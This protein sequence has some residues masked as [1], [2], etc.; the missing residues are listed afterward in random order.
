MSDINHN[1]LAGLNEKQKASILTEARRVLVLAGAGS[2]KTKTVISK[3]LYLIF[4]K[5]IK[6]SSI[7]AITFTKNAANEMIDRLIV[8]SDSSNTYE[9]F[10][11]NK[12]I[13][14]IQKDAERKKR[15]LAQ[16]WISNLTI[17]TFHSL[18]YK[19]LR[20]NGN[21]VFD[22][23]FKLITE[24]G[25]DEAD[26]KGMDIVTNERPKDIIGKML[27][28]ACEDRH[29]FLKLKR[30]ILDYY[31][32]KI[33]LEKEIKSYINEGQRTYTTLKGE[34]VKSKS[35]R[36]IADWLFRHNIKYIYE[37]VTNFKD[38]NFKPDFFIPQANLY[39][40]HVTDKSYSMENKE[41]QF[42][43]SGK[44]CVITYESI[45]NN[46]M[47]FN[48]SME[49]IIMGKITA[50]ISESISLNFEEEFKSYHDKVGEFLKTVLRLQSMMKAEDLNPTDLLKK[51]SSNEHERIRVFYEL[52]IPLIDSYKKYCTNK[53]YLDFDD[54]IVL[55]V[56]LL[57]ENPEVRAFYQNKYKYL[58]VD[59]FQD[60]NGLQVKLLDLL[61]KPENQLFC[62]GDDWQ[63]IYGFRGSDVEYIVNYE[64]YYKDCE[65]YKLEVNYRSTQTIVGA[66]NEVIKNNKRQISK[67]IKAFKKAPNKIQIFRAKSLEEDGVEFLV[68]EVKK[69]YQKG[70][71]KD[72]IL[73][74]YRRSK[75]FNEYL[76]AL[77]ENRLFVSS[78]TIHAAKGLEAKAVF[79]IG[80]K[81]GS[82]GFPD[83]WLD[84]AI[85]RIIK[86]I[87][88]DILLEEERRLFY[89][90]ITR[91][92]DEL[93]LITE[94]GNESSFVEEIPKHFFH[95]DKPKLN[96]IE[97]SIINCDKC[98]I[99]INESDNFCSHCGHKLT[100]KESSKTEPKKIPDYVEKARLVHKNAYMNW[101][102]ENDL[103][104]KELF[105]AGKSKEELSN[106]FGRNIGA[107]NARINKLG[108]D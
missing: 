88:Y 103:K 22:N 32:D 107:I 93:F 18:C 57:K 81:E 75:M 8:S 55:T 80:L 64:K 104:L 35:E 95:F 47:L 54:L 6:P 15:I 97:E 76:R 66:S 29:Y 51:S 106:Y 25:I 43:Q 19:I 23:K 52:A 13:T 39:L 63:S 10:I 92:K 99:S 59:E 11:Q 38:F 17:R 101:S 49:R 65:I 71:G 1:F 108:L 83:I 105:L 53:S 37:K 40:E 60:V 73:V 86:D 45:M 41:K 26:L 96:N 16:P 68:E 2:G 9:A 24:N 31:V 14:S 4:E 67:E 82:G 89:V 42:I 5:N 79:I 7:L 34:T 28:L 84:D 85:F 56:K 36:D 62:V 44:N 61:L 74:L 33:S 48:L 70:M 69:L 58:M 20:D 50:E 90:A 87:K 27:I 102:N 78:K 30:Y 46:S 3:L 21:A 77:K 100:H 98:G 72:D 12:S 94:L 91:A